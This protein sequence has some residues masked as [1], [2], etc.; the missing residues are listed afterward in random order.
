M[1]SARPSPD[2]L[3]RLRE[4]K[5]RVHS[6]ARTLSPEA[7]VR[8]VIELQRI[9]LPQIARRRALRKHEFVWDD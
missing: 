7:K 3:E 6:A 8:Q 2:L 4:G 9:V 5:R 1:S